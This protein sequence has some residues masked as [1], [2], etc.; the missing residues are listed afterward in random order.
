MSDTKRKRASAKVLRPASDEAWETWCAIT[1]RA[2]QPTRHEAAKVSP[3]AVPEAEDEPRDDLQYPYAPDADGK[4]RGDL[5]LGAVV[6]A[7]EAFGKALALPDPPRGDPL[8]RERLW[9]AAIVLV[10]VGGIALMGFV[11]GWRETLVAVLG[12]LVVLVASLRG[13]VAAQREKGLRRAV[14]RGG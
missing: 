1:A 4:P 2:P 6:L 14:E 13:L 9:G 11:S 3:D 5:P 10:L 7:T 8:V 12:I